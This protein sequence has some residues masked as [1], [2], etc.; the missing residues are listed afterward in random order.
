MSTLVASVSW[1]QIEAMIGI[2][3]AALLSGESFGMF[4]ALG[5]TAVVGAGVIEVAGNHQGRTRAGEALPL[6]RLSR[7]SA[8]D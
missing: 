5:A 7:R 3:S 8:S 4:H 1:L 6:L 2:T